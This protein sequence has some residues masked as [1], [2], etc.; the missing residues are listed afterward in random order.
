MAKK[1]VAKKAAKKAPKKTPAKKAAPKK[2][3]PKKTVAKKAPKKAV[4]KKKK[5]TLGRPVVS[6]EEQLY[7]LFKDDYHARQ[8]FE[9]L[10]VRTVGE[11]EQ[12][13]PQEIVYRLSQ[14]VVDSVDRIRR[15]L[16]EKNRCLAG[17]IDFALA[18]K[19]S[20]TPAK[21]PA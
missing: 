14:P 20:S 15:A 21:K 7:M 5:P 19:A 17:D 16:A 12:F 10:R 4:K 2:T 13:T 18:H 6:A 8:I 9:F 1:K 3:A 11:L